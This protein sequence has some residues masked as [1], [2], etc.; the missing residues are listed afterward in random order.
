MIR[1]LP[2][3]QIPVRSYQ[4]ASQRLDRIHS[5]NAYSDSRENIPK[6]W[7]VEFSP[8]ERIC[9]LYSDSRENIPKIWGV[10]FC[11]FERI[12]W[13]V[14][15]HWF[16]VFR[17]VAAVGPSSFIPCVRHLLLLGRSARLSPRMHAA[18][19]YYSIC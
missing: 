17:F 1:T 8:F 10:E 4:P 19:T 16:D 15:C 14:P 12:R 9:W 5:H 13:L 3:N 2:P 6:I 7:G 18:A 11:P